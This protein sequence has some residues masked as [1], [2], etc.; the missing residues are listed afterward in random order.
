M[1]WSS[2]LPDAD[3]NLVQALIKLSRQF[4]ATR[5]TPAER[6]VAL[7]W[8]LHLLADLHQ[9]LHVTTLYAAD[10][11]PDGDR[12]GN[13]IAIAGGSNLHAMWDGALGSDRRWGRINSLARQYQRAPQ[14]GSAVNLRDWAEESRRTAAQFVYSQLVRD[15]VF[16]APT[17][18][19]VRVKLDPD[20]RDT[21]GRIAQVQIGLAGARTAAIL[22][23]LLPSQ[24]GGACPGALAF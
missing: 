6:A 14:R 5:T 12:G 21:M 20:Y 7:S 23:M 3:L 2:N 13:D 18:G 10:V 15:A 11:F 16:A 1:T 19:A 4:C 22:A 9:P 24:G 8:L 17:E